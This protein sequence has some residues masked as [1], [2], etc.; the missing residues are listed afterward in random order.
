VQPQGFLDHAIE[1]LRFGDVLGVEPR[2]AVEE[3]LQ[4]G[5]ELVDLGGVLGE[6]VEEEGEG[7]G[8]G[9][10]AADDGQ[11]GVAAQ[12]LVV[13]VLLGALVVGGDE[14]GEDLC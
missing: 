6:V 7:R 10:G 4:L 13:D 11:A 2:L 3:G 1:V 8:G 9:V 12:P 5:A 14:V